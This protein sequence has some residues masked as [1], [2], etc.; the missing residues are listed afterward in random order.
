VKD[1]SG[2]TLM[3]TLCAIALILACAG[4]AGGLAYSVRRISGSM[5]EHSSQQYL[6]LRIER[7][8]REA[9]EGVS[10][11]YWERDERGLQAA[12]EAV[13]KALSE[14]AY[15]S[16]VEFETIQDGMGRTRGVL[17][18]CRIDGREYEALGLFAS[19][20]LAREGL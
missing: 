14:A 5:Q 12:K 10:L 19:V 6:Q 18:R 17:C 8:I 15:R 11:P 3:E 4:T 20:P 2:F 7:L 1:E 16:G 13:E 9:V